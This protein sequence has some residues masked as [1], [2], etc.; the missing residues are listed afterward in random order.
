MILIDTGPIVAMIDKNDTHYSRVAGILLGTDQNF[1]TTEACLTEAVYLL[2]RSI[3]WTGV[4]LLHESLLAGAIEVFP[5]GQAQ[6]HR[7]F[8]YMERFRDQP[9]DYADAT[10]LVAAEETGLRRIFTIDLHFHAYRL[11]SGEALKM[12]P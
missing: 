10:L 7:A 4:D 1:G 11:T 3:G 6:A 9:C 2:N 8:A 5:S 12:L